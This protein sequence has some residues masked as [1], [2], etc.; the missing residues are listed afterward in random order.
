[1]AYTG[2]HTLGFL[3]KCTLMISVRSWEVGTRQQALIELNTPSFSVLNDT[4]LPPSTSFP[5][6][7]SPVLSIISTV[8]A[9]RSRTI[10]A[11]SLSSPQPFFPSDGSAADPASNGVAALIA[12][13]TGQSNSSFDFGQ[14]AQDQLQ[15]LWEKVPRAQNGALSHRTSEVQL[16][17]DFVYMVPPFL[18]Y[19]GV[20]SENKSLVL[21]SYNQVAK[22]RDNLW[23][24]DTGLWMH[25]VVS[26][27]LIS[28]FFHAEL[29]F[30]KKPL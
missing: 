23:D 18:A 13:Y 29:G 27:E 19:Y 20:L 10:S 14:A 17:S 7:L 4:S 21:E 5:S 2:N 1:M 9:N 28:H 8:L 15:F 12:N 3:L 30:I 11:S 26:A 24:K 22:Y 25:V 16:W 6:T